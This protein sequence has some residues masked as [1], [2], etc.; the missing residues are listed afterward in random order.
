MSAPDSPLLKDFIF[1]R[2]QVAATAA[3][4]ASAC[5]HRPPDARAALLRSPARASWEATASTPWLRSSAMRPISPLPASRGTIIQVN[6][7]DLDTLQVDRSRLPPSCRAVPSGRGQRS[8][9]CGRRHL[10]FGS[11]PSGR[12]RQLPGRAVGTSLMDGSA[13]GT[14]LKGAVGEVRPGK[15]GETFGKTF[16][17]PSPDPIPPLPKTFG[18]YR[19]PV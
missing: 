18:I 12:R 5:N 13:P 14:A 2:L 15:G 1:D 3:T 4:P 7:R 19:I 8:M 16:S 9:D 6:A 17:S 10:R 11:S